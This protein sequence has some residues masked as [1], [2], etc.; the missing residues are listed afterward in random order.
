MAL[1][2][3]FRRPLL[4]RNDV[5]D[6]RRS[7]R[8][9]NPTSTDRCSQQQSLFFSTLPPELRLKIYSYILPAYRDYQ[10]VHVNQRVHRIPWYSGSQRF[11]YC[12]TVSWH[13]YGGTCTWPRCS[14]SFR[15]RSPVIPNAMLSCR[16]MYD[17]M[18]RHFQSTKTPYI[19]SPLDLIQLFNGTQLQQF[20]YIASIRFVFCANYASPSSTFNAGNFQRA[21]EI[22]Q[23]MPNLQSLHILLSRTCWR[24]YFRQKMLKEEGA[25]KT[26]YED[27][28][29]LLQRPIDSSIEAVIPFLGWL[30]TVKCQGDILVQMF[31]RSISDMVQA[32]D[33]K[34]NT[35]T[36]MR[37]SD[38]KFVAC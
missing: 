8:S 34:M 32:S 7:K 6:T 20:N 36:Q 24:H 16:R 25:A 31:G 3:K 2:K 35:V 19:D 18:S 12:H 22:L 11:V 30:N 37:L 23:R 33:G 28:R 29:E 26:D 15:D 21:V 17:E 13:G 1:L 38:G 10:V 9:S 27:M 5:E 14:A 4:R